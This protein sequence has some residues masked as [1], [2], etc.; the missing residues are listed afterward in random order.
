MDDTRTEEHD[1]VWREV[2]DEFLRREAT[3]RV[4]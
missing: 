2:R 1:R 3:Y 4:S